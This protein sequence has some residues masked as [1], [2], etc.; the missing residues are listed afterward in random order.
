RDHGAETDKWPDRQ[1]DAAVQHQ[2][3]LRH[4]DEGE[5]EPVLR[6]FREAAHREDARKEDRI[7]DKKGGDDEIKAAEATVAAALD[8]GIK[9]AGGNDGTHA[10]T[11]CSLTPMAAPTIASSLIA[12]PESEAATRPSRNTTARSQRWTSSGV[13]ELAR[14]TRRPSAAKLRSMT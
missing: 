12:A 7:E 6:E 14:M 13:S 1:R 8:G 10:A 3:R 11:L 4:G 2:Q 9:R 5:R